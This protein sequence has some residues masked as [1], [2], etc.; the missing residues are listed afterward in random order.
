[1][2]GKRQK[3]NEENVPLERQKC[4]FCLPLSSGQIKNPDNYIKRM[5]RVPKRFRSTDHQQLKPV[6]REFWDDLMGDAA[7]CRELLANGRGVAFVGPTG[8]GKSR[9]AAAVAIRETERG[10]WPTWLPC[11]EIRSAA[12][13]SWGKAEELIK[14]MSKARLLVLDDLG[15]GTPSNQSDEIVFQILDNRTAW[16][17]P[18][19]ITSQ[20]NKEGLRARFKDPTVAEAVERRITDYHEIFKLT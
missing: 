18:T 17:R 4:S 3:M 15:K 20:H 9:C 10:T 8:A 1:M 11:G 13:G 5:E 2:T 14:E 7:Y 12:L 6:A 16:E 19:I